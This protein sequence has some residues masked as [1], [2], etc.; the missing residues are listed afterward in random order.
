VGEILGESDAMN[1]PGPEIFLRPTLADLCADWAA[2][3]FSPRAA[4]RELVAIHLRYG[5]ARGK[6]NRA[7]RRMLKGAIPPF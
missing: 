3:G 7:R 5:N 2:Y 4:V 6:G 1:L